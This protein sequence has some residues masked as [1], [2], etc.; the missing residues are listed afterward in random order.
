[1]LSHQRYLSV[2]SYDVLTGLYTL[3][4]PMRLRDNN[5]RDNNHEED[6]HTTETLDSV[7]MAHHSTVTLDR[8][9]VVSSETLVSV[10]SLGLATVMS[11]HP[12]DGT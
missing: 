3:T 12:T 11:F 6:K 5:Y 4:Q 2:Q 1:M 9:R 10:T 7:V 8:A